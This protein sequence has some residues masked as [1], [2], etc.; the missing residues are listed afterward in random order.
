MNYLLKVT[1]TN[2][3]N[4]KFI[5]QVIDETGAIISTRKSNRVY[6]ACTIDG[7]YYFGRIDLIGKGDHGR[8]LKGCDFR[9]QTPAPIAY[10]ENTK[11]PKP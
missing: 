5:Y 10:I 3:K 6:V 2:N 7:A 11:T 8:H 9:Q 1:E 4:G